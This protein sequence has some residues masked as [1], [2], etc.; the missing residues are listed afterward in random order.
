[1]KLCIGLN[2]SLKEANIG[3]VSLSIE[4]NPDIK[5]DARVL[6]NIKNES[7]EIIMASAVL[8]HLNYCGWGSARVEKTVQYLSLW[9]SKL[10]PEGKLY[11]CVP[12]L[13]IAIKII[14]EN[15][16]YWEIK[17]TKWKDVMGMFYGAGANVYNIHTMIYNYT[18]LEYCLKQAGFINI[19]KI[20][21]TEIPP[22][23]LEYNKD[24]SDIRGLCVYA[25]KKNI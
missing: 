10:I 13:D 15:P 1:M 12:D 21:S 22:E 25:E 19:K 23:I 17:N 14:Q 6:K 16:I 11:V 2:K 9:N 7:C 5:D 3:W 8:E 24:A 20:K 4:G 18:C